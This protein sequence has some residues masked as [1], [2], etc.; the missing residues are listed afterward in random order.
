M[1]FSKFRDDVHFVL[2]L[3]SYLDAKPCQ[4]LLICQEKHLLLP[5]HHQRI[6]IYL[7]GD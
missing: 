2:V 1:T 4:A 7:T 5:T 3:I 6:Y